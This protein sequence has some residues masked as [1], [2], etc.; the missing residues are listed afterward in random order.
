MRK[1]NSKFVRHPKRWCLLLLLCTATHLLDARMCAYTFT[2]DN[3][4]VPFFGMGSSCPIQVSIREQVPGSCNY[5]GDAHVG[6]EG[7]AS[8][9]CSNWH[10]TNSRVEVHFNS[11]TGNLIVYTQVDAEY[12]LGL[13]E[14]TYGRGWMETIHYI[15]LPQNCFDHCL[16]K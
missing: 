4:V 9:S 6:P 10:V 13:A 11:F 7:S 2:A 16:S 12:V 1:G 8:L 15:N 14:I 3:M 5:A